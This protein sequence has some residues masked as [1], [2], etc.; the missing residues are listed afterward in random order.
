MAKE[1]TLDDL[2][3]E[4]AKAGS[5]K[6]NFYDWHGLNKDL[7]LLINDIHTGWYDSL[8]LTITEIGNHKLFIYYMAF[9]TFY[10]VVSTLS[11]K[12]TRRPGMKV[13]MS[14]WF[15]VLT[16]LLIGYGAMGLTVKTLKSEVALPRPY[17]A[18]GSSK[19]TLLQEQPSEKDYESFPSGHSAFIAFMVTALWP[20]LGGGLGFIAVMLVLLTGWSRIALGVHF[21]AD[22]IGGLMI[23]FFITLTVRMIL[24]SIYRKLFRLPC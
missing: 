21:P 11:R 13:H 22:V 24:Y 8:M 16:V 18:L 6:E 4:F 7:F 10:A 19:V 17:E 14:K 3:S 20:V 12:L 2:Y 5:F 15:G 23:G 1:S 9:I